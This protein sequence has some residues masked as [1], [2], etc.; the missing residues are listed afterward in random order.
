MKRACFILAA[1]II[2]SL[3]ALA[4]TNVVITSFGGNGQLTWTNSPG[5][6]AFRIEWAGNLTGSNVWNRNWWGLQYIQTT[7][8]AN[9]ATVPMFY[10]VAQ[11]TNKY[12]NAM[13]SNA[14]LTAVRGGAYFF[15]DGGGHLLDAI[16][17]SIPS[18]PGGPYGYYQ[19]MDDGFFSIV[20][21]PPPSYRSPTAIGGQLTSPTQAICQYPGFAAGGDV[22]KVL[23]PGLCQGSWTGTL[24][25]TSP[26]AATYSLSLTVDSAGGIT[27]LTG[28]SGPIY[29]HMFSLST[30]TGTSAMWFRT[31][32]SG[33]YNQVHI[34]GSLS[35]RTFTGTFGVDSPDIGG[36]ALLLRQ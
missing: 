6:N 35:N 20:V 11:D 25:Q 28:F 29:G 30:N 2:A 22:F 24:H 17:S 15:L 34:G 26:S 9:I 10:R 4:E 19:V 18:Y 12:D 7:G 1:G 31:G 3:P 33:S 32:E 23:N 21:A 13:F 16:G 36:D 8:T 5:T 27:N 14:W